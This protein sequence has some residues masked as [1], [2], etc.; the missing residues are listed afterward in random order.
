M[1]ESSNLTWHRKGSP[2]NSDIQHFDAIKSV[3]FLELVSDYQLLKKVFDVWCLVRYTKTRINNSCTQ[4]ICTIFPV[5]I[6]PTAPFNCFSGQPHHTKEVHKLPQIYEPS[7]N[8]RCQT[9]LSNLH[10]EN[11]QISEA[12]LQNLVITVAWQQEFVYPCHTITEYTFF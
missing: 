12:A 2:S 6:L 8:S 10:T 5:T 9:T 1:M 4:D 3:T 7:Q 11:S